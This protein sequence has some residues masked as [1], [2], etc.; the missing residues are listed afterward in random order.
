M[1]NALQALAHALAGGASGVSQGIGDITQRRRQDQNMELQKEQLNQQFTAQQ[2]EAGY[3]QQQ[4]HELERHNRVSEQQTGNTEEDRFIKNTDNLGINFVNPRMALQAMNAATPPTPNYD[5]NAGFN[6]IGQGVDAARGYLGAQ[7]EQKAQGEFYKNA[8]AAGMT[9]MSR[10]MPRAFVKGSERYG[11]AF[12]QGKPFNPASAQNALIRAE[13]AED[14]QFA[15]SVASARVNVERAKHNAL[16]SWARDNGISDITRLT[17]DP[18]MAQVRRKAEAYANAEMSRVAQSEYAMLRGMYP[19]RTMSMSPGLLMGSDLAPQAPTSPRAPMTQ[20]GRGATP[21]LNFN[22]NDP[23][24]LTQKAA[25]GAPVQPGINATTPSPQS[26][27]TND[28]LGLFK[29]NP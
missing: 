18:A 24:G 17:D 1:G 4:L 19:D 2:Q 13:T 21:P 3:R 27:L 12:A 5:P 23:L 7:N 15:R 9:A 28:P 14:G 29:K 22:P 10:N 20:P 16:Q 25:G 26:S 8:E 11:G 6:P